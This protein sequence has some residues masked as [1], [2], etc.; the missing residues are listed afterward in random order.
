[1]MRILQD[2]ARRRLFIGTS[3]GLAFVLFVLSR[4][5]SF[6]GGPVSGR[7]RDLETLQPIAGAIVVVL[8]EGPAMGLVHS[9]SVCF[10]VETAVSDKDGKFHMP[11][12]LQAPPVWSV[13]GTSTMRDAYLP[14][15][16][17]VSTYKTQSESPE[18]V[19]M[20]KFTGGEAARFE[21]I[22]QQVFGAMTCGHAGTSARN[23]YPVLKAAFR[24]AKA[25][26]NS[27][28]QNSEVDGMRRIAADTWLAKAAYGP[29]D[30]EPIMKVPEEIRRDL[31]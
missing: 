19:F 3:V 21:Y 18:D 24:E 27:A 26:A 12:W 14:G 22:S 20:K 16:E 2:R 4:G 5:C 31:Q 6:A 13:F 9:S 17:S 29:Y 11:L 15:Y 7:V 10:H 1:M 23:L 25:L 30:P 8:W 28:Q